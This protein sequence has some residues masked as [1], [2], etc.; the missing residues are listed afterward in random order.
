MLNDVCGVRYLSQNI[1]FQELLAGNDEQVT[2]ARQVSSSVH[3]RIVSFF[4]I[5]HF[6]VTL[7]AA[8]LWFIMPRLQA[9]QKQHWPGAL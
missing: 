9:W 8:G 1:A 3:R 7:T 2:F 5:I 4:V 6:W